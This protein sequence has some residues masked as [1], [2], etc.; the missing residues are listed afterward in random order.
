MTV[1][2]PDADADVIVVGAGPGGSATAYHLARQGARVL[3]LERSTFPRSKVCG[4]GLTPR[5]VQQVQA[6]DIDVTT[7]DWV[8]NE[9]VRFVGGR[10][11]LEL[12]WPV[13]AGAPGFGLTRPRLD[14]DALLAQRATTAGADLMPQ[15]T[16]TGP[17]PADPTG[18]TVG[19]I[20]QVG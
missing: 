10:T 2:A 3:L 13:V 12:A 7:P 15:T 18:G 6:M 9:G 20:A 11:R 1:R 14:L 19:V 17:S 4:D 8:R 16:V 5:G